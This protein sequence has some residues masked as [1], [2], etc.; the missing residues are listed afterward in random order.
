[1]PESPVSRPLS[2]SLVGT[3]E[4]QSRHDIAADGERRIEPMLG[5]DPIA[6]LIYDRTGH[7]SAQF[8]KRNRADTFQGSP[9]GAAVNNSRA[10]DGYDAYFGTYVVDDA[11]GTVT[12]QILGAL[13]KETVGQVLTRAMVVEGDKL[14][15]TL[16]TSSVQGEPVTRT[17]IWQRI[18]RG[19]QSE[20]ENQ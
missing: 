18:R 3:W 7:F 19:R 16:Q 14:T 6:L 9:A 2:E 1:M 13:S 11:Q 10:Q 12:Q 17:L 4:L 15:I 8:M 20:E 5:A